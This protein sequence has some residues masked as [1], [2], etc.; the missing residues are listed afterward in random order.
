MTFVQYVHDL[1]KEYYEGKKEGKDISQLRAEI[2]EIVLTGEQIMESGITNFSEMIEEKEY[3]KRIDKLERYQEAYKK[4]LRKLA[5]NDNTET[6][7][8]LKVKIAKIERIIHGKYGTI[9]DEIK[10]AIR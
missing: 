7:N 1:F 6:V 4:G 9:A 8:L 3:K 5:Q 10:D 2:E